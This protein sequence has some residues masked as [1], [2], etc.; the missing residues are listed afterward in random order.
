[1]SRTRFSHAKYSKSATFLLGLIACAGCAAATIPQKPVT[2]A[3]VLMLVTDEKPVI[4]EPEPETATHDPHI[5]AMRC[6]QPFAT[7]TCHAIP[8]DPTAPVAT[9]PVAPPETFEFDRSGR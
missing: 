6:V 7:D 4:V 9:R 3:Q 2:T 8:V 5:W 1:M